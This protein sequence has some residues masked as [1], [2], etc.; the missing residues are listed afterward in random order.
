MTVVRTCRSCNAN[1]YATQD[2][3][4][5][6][7]PFSPL[8]HPT[9]RNYTPPPYPRRLGTQLDGHRRQPGY[10]IS[11]SATH[12]SDLWGPC[13]D[14]AK[15]ALNLICFQDAPRLILHRRDR[16]A[17]RAPGMG[18][19]KADVDL[20]RWEGIFVGKFERCLGN[21]KILRDLR[22]AGCRGVRW[23]LT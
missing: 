9:H 7:K 19:N 18:F 16:L 14:L 6:P 10:P 20:G 12:R 22:F 21:A 5:K 4:L 2:H 3:L 8:F 15:G 13:E 1:M 11:K 23:L 17:A